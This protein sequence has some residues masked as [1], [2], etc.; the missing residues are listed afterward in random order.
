MA[1]GNMREI[2]EVTPIV[3]T[4]MLGTIER[5]GWGRRVIVRGRMGWSVG[6]APPDIHFLRPGRVQ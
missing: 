4:A 2:A 5:R 6:H 1:A 3:A